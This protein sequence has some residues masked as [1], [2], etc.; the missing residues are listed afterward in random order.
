MQLA[1]RKVEGC[2]SSCSFEVKS[3]VD[4]GEGGDVGVA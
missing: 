1:F 2:G 3:L 4:D